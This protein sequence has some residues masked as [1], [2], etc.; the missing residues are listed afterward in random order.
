MLNWF[1]ELNLFYWSLFEV[2]LR[3]ISLQSALKFNYSATPVS[4]NDWKMTIGWV[5]SPI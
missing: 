2:Y 4:V 5:M 1:L 3:F